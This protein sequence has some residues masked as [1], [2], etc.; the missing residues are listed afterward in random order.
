MGTLPIQSS[1]RDQLLR[2][3]MIEMPAEAYEIKTDYLLMSR[4]TQDNRV[5]L[6]NFDSKK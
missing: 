6:Q 4:I 2:F 5:T 3:I 1:I